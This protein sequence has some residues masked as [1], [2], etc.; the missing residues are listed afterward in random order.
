MQSPRPNLL[1]NFGQADATDAEENLEQA[2]LNVYTV[3]LRTSFR[4][5]QK[6]FNAA[7]GVYLSR[8]P[9]VSEKAARQAVAGLICHKL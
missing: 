4:S 7:V 1:D 3:A 9:N 8:H 6:A 5:E 2:V